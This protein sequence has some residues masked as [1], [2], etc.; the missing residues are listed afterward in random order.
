MNIAPPPGKTGPDHASAWARMDHNSIYTC[1]RTTY[2]EASNTGYTGSSFCD[3]TRD[4]DCICR[5]KVN[6]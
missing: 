5:L 6:W 2:S 3:T 4:G 1:K